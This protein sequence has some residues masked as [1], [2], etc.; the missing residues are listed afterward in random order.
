[1]RLVT[2]Y[3]LG[4]A[5]FGALALL[6]PAGTGRALAGPGGATPDA[7]AFLRG[8]GG[9]ELGLAFGLLRA[10]GNAI[11][12]WIA[13]GVLADCGDMA[14][15]AGGWSELAPGKR[16]PGLAFAAAAA[17]AGLAVLALSPPEG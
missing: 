7:R 5:A 14:G 17:A 11:R 4:R 16:G 10:R 13:A 3:A 2:T 15:L 9:R 12:P 8:L 6:A 1:M